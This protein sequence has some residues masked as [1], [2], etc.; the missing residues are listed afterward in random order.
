M[1]LS[2]LINE[3]RRAEERK[4][5]VDTFKKLAIGSAIGALA[6]ILFA[7]KSGKEFRKDISDKTKET[8]EA[9]KKTMKDLEGKVKEEIKNKINEVKER[10]MFEIEMDNNIPENNN[11]VEHEKIEEENT[12]DEVAGE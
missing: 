10:K 8:A 3:K 2:D 7:P 6:G 11:D 5:K 4:R 9:T 1:K 12:D